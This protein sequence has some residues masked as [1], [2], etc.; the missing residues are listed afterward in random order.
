[1]LR[2]RAGECLFLELLETQICQLLYPKEGK[3]YFS[4]S[5]ID[6]LVDAT[7]D[8][9]LMNFANAYYAYNQIHMHE[10]DQIKMTFVSHGMYCY[11]VMTFGVK[12]ARAM[13][14]HLVNHMFA[15]QIGRTMEVYVDDMLV[16]SLTAGDHGRNLR[17]MFALLR[18]YKMKLNPNKCIFGVDN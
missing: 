14:Q 4:L 6:Q 12:N 17:E 1:M 8:H 3:D 2:P 18:K 9:E 10:P 5:C 16:K 13:Y 15:D 7:A 11:K